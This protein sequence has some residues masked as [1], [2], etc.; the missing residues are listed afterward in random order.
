MS[1]KL[2]CLATAGAMSVLTLAGASAAQADTK[3]AIDKG[4]AF[5]FQFGST[6]PG[7][8][9]TVLTLDI[10]PADHPTKQ[11]LWWASGV[12]RGT[13]VDVLTENY[14]NNLNGTATLAKPNNGKPGAKLIHMS[15]TGT[16][17]G[18]YTDPAKT[19]LWDL[20]FNLQLNRKTLKGKIV[21][22]SVFTPISGTTA[23]TATTLA[24]DE[25]ITPL[26]CKKA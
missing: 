24:I 11:P 5:C 15:L 23:G 8:T 3:T 26:N 10:A 18:S 4:G 9:R 7:A 20:S 21:G 6:E 19:G 2:I 13:N 22:L 25:K 14:V 12:E 1:K 17:F 16:S